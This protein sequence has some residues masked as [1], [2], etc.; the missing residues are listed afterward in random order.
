LAPGFGFD[1]ARDLRVGAGH[2]RDGRLVHID[3]LGLPGLFTRGYKR[4]RSD[5]GAEDHPGL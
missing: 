5:R 1:Q 3:L 2:V 4:V